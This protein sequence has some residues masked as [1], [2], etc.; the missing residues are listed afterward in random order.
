MENLKIK[1][2]LSLK[3]Y[4]HSHLPLS[5]PLLAWVFSQSAC[6]LTAAQLCSILAQSA[7]SVSRVVSELI[8]SCPPASSRAISFS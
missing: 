3:L 6:W 8:A 4:F 1:V 2:S 7:L 5:S